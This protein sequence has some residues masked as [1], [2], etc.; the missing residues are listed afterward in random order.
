MVR[1]PG[2]L[3]LVGAALLAGTGAGSARAPQPA[4]ERYPVV[5]TR[6]A[7]DAAP[8]CA[9]AEVADLVWSFFVPFNRG[10]GRAATAIIDPRAGPKDVRPRG[11]YSVTEGRRRHFVAY[12]RRPLLRYFAAR[13]RRHERLR[14]LELAVGP[15]GEGT[16]GFSFRVRR[17]AR[18]LRSIGITNTVAT[19][20][21]SVACGRGKIFVWSMAHAP[22]RALGGPLCPRPEEEYG[23][24]TIA[25]SRR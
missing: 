22:R 5:V 10:K 25:C 23:R 8:G 6:E 7:T 9:P 16:A 21:G 4:G 13:H 11:W 12:A 1:G 14:L 24:V 17:T 19:G 2:L 15:E 18:D 20:K 3:A